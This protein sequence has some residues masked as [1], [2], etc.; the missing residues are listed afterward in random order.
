MNVINKYNTA[1]IYTIRSPATERYY[2]GSTTQKLCKR[3]SDHKV[4]YKLY[5]DAKHHFV[6]SFKILE[7]GDA[8]I[9]LLEE[10]ECDNKT[11]LEKR[12]GEFIRIHKDNCVNKRIEGRTRVEYRIDNN[13]KLSKQYE[14]YRIDNKDKIKENNKQYRIDNKESLS[15]QHKQYYNDNKES[16]LKQFKQYRTDNKDK[17]IQYRIDNKDKTIQNRIDN[18]DKIKQHYIDNKESILKQNKQY[19]TDNKDKI[20]EQRKQYSVENKEKIS[21]RA[22]K[23]YADK[24]LLKALEQEIIIV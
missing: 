4:K 10:Y 5:L 19:R 6:T 20:K 15:A 21:E 23:R 18:N 9:E 3:F 12:E 14:Q 1:M 22:K 2:I 16:K 7:L 13:D 11:Q 17:I 24:K 8:Y